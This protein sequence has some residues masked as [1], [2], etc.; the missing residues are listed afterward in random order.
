MKEYIGPALAEIELLNL[1]NITTAA[2]VVID[3]HKSSNGHTRLALVSGMISSDGPGNI[4][5]H[6]RRLEYNTQLIRSSVN[7]PVLSARDI[8]SDSVYAQL[9]E[10]ELPAD[11]REIEFKRFW[12]NLLALT[13]PNGQQHFTD[14]FRTPYDWRSK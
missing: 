14:V 6:L 10:M 5:H 9:A 2:S 4:S 13:S 3:N 7:F 1:A 8:F 12:R 11:V